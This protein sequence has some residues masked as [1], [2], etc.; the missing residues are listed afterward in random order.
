MLDQLRPEVVVVVTKYDRLRCSLQDL[1]TLVEQD[2]ACNTGFRSLAE[3]IDSTTPADRLAFHVFA[4]IAQFERKLIIER[5]CE[6]LAAAH[7]RG[8]VEGRA[9]APSA[10]QKE[11]V[12]RLRYR[13]GSGIANCRGCP[14]Q[15]RTPSGRHKG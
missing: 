3:D 6:G 14:G 7:N 10:E 4:S 15:A 11:E 8:R 9:P 12:R 1:L 2:R 5:S 13:D